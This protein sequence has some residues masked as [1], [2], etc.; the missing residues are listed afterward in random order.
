[1]NQS[2]SLFG[3][4]TT[5]ARTR[6]GLVMF[7]HI[8]FWCGFIFLPFLLMQPNSD[9][10]RMPRSDRQ[11][12]NNYFEITFF[13]VNT[14]SVLLFYFNSEWL[15]PKFL[16]KK[17]GQI[18]ALLVIC[19]IG[20]GLVLNYFV[21]FQL[22]G[23]PP[24]SFF[25]FTTFYLFLSVFAISACY[26]LLTD[27]Q[28]NQRL[29]TEREK[30]RLQ[31]ELSFLRSQ[32]SPH[33]MFNLMNSLAALARKKS[34]LLEPM[35][36]KMSNLLRY[37]LY[38]SDDTRV[39]IDREIEYLNSYIDLQKMR[40]GDHV[41]IETNFDIQ[42]HDLSLEPM[43]L[44][45]FVENAF[46]HGT[47]YIREPMIQIELQTTTNS[48]K[49]SVKNRY[50]SEFNEKKDDS[51]GIGLSNVR[52]RLELLYT[53]THQLDINEKDGWFQSNLLFSNVK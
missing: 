25:T 40:F 32:I 48:L 10:P 15:I 13:F 2:F 51:S 38:D 12:P 3:I 39:P 35:I 14:L 29:V 28:R 7:A 26:R 37:M 46:K 50:N 27:Y 49:F 4:K 17:N 6:R 8:L 19:T 33:F 9:G 16:K 36:V 44:I 23:H 43:L 18:Y 1:M 21:R 41:K 45:P 53:A 20:I 11:L 24:R 42:N 47:G 22:L 31:S 5:N 30:V 34:D 52:R